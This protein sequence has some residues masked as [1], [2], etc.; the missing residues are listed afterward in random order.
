MDFFRVGGLRMDFLLQAFGGIFSVGAHVFFFFFL[1]KR[2]IKPPSGKTLKEPG[3]HNQGPKGFR[4]IPNGAT[5]YCKMR[6]H[7]T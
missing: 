2:F 3:S 7:W 1:K 5:F 6:K 4:V